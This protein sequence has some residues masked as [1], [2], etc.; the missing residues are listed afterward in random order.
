MKMRRLLQ[1]AERQKQFILTMTESTD[2]RWIFKWPTGCVVF[3][4]FRNFKALMKG[5]AKA[6]ISYKMVV[7]VV[8]NFFVALIM[9]KILRHIFMLNMSTLITVAFITVS[10]FFFSAVSNKLSADLGSKIGCWKEVWLRRLISQW[11]HMCLDSDFCFSYLGKN[12]LHRVHRNTRCRSI[13]ARLLLQIH[14]WLKQTKLKLKSK[15]AGN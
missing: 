6:W 12:A 13:N 9:T 11:Y 1:T 10:S 2:Y 4:G 15:D 7:F 14:N 8:N 5:S 3:W